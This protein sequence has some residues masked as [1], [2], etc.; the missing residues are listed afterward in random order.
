MNNDSSQS[1]IILSADISSS[2]PP[3]APSSSSSSS[4]SSSKKPLTL[5]EF[6]KLRQVYEA[7]R[8]DL[9]DD[10]GMY[11]ALAAAY[12]DLPGRGGHS[13]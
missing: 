2:I 13:S 10:E 9:D 7:N 11:A 6:R 8:R 3:Q 5:E 4:S 1:R 12:E